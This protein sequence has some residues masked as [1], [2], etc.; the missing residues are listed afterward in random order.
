MVN[1]NGDTYSTYVMYVQYGRYHVL[2]RIR[3]SLN[4][5]LEAIVQAIH[6]ANPT[7]VCTLFSNLLF[8][9]DRGL[10]NSER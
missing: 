8:V 10:W 2:V 5:M 3:I 6:T 4:R 9:M 1:V 7:L